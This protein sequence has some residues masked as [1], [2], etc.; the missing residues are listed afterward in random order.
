M[1]AIRSA[2][3]TQ[4]SPLRV[5]LDGA[6]TDS[7]ADSIAL[8]PAL[9]SRVRVAAFGKQLLVLSGHHDSGWTW[10]TTGWLNGAS[11]YATSGSWVP[12]YRKVNGIVYMA[13]LFNSGATT[14]PL[15]VFTLPVG[16]RP[17]SGETMIAIPHTGA[18]IRRMDISPAGAMILR[19]QHAGAA[20]TGWHNL[21]VVQFV[22]EN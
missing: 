4:V 2:T 17:G 11:P 22:Q 20:T 6:T 8:P 9:N 19:E 18:G 1:T 12:R 13:G 14:T 21:T 10:M 3:V 5:R 16:Y 15:H 7:S